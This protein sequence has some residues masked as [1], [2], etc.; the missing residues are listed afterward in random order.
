MHI[1]HNTNR[2]GIIALNLG[3]IG[4]IDFYEAMGVLTRFFAA[5]SS[6]LRELVKVSRPESGSAFSCLESSFYQYCKAELKLLRA[7]HDEQ[8]PVD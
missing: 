2:Y 1:D 6:S 4:F 3:K 5:A 8:L 7:E